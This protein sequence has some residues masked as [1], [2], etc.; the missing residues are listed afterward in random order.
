MITVHLSPQVHFP[1][2]PDLLCTSVFT[3]LK[4]LHY[5]VCICPPATGWVLPMRRFHRTPSTSYQLQK[6]TLTSLPSISWCQSL[7]ANHNA[8]ALDR[9]RFLTQGRGRV[10]SALARPCAPVSW[11]WGMTADK[12]KSARCSLR[13]FS[14][15]HPWSLRYWKLGA[16]LKQEKIIPQNSGCVSSSPFAKKVLR[17]QDL[18]SWGRAGLKACAHETAFL[19]RKNQQKSSSGRRRKNSTTDSL[20]CYLCGRSSCSAALPPRL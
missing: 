20:L 9:I 19:K 15:H 8:Q 2:F 13:L 10:R 4:S 18:F 3:C 17:V 7:E 12:R 14:P 1:L 11:G 6:R 16:R 5:P